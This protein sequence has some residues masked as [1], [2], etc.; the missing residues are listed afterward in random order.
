MPMYL[1]LKIAD[2]ASSRLKRREKLEFFYLPVAV[3][4][5]F[6]HHPRLASFNLDCSCLTLQY[7]LLISPRNQSYLFS[8]A[9]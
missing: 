4:V 8:S 1:H 5:D 3:S 9:Q 2:V 6:L 7:H